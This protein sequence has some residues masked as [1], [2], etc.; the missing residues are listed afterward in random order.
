MS[1]VEAQAIT[2]SLQ[3]SQ[4]THLNRRGFLRQALYATKLLGLGTLAAACSPLERLTAPAQKTPRELKILMTTATIPGVNEWIEIW[5]KRWGLDNKIVVD[6]V[7]MGPSQM[8]D[9]IKVDGVRKE[10]DIVTPTRAGY[11]Y[12]FGEQFADLDQLADELGNK[13]GGWIDQA[14]NIAQVNGRW[15][16]IPLYYSPWAVLFKKDLFGKVGAS[17]DTTWESLISAGKLLKDTGLPQVGIPTSANSNDANISWNSFLLAYGASFISQDGKTV[18]I[19]SEQTRQ[20]LTAGI[21]LI[22]CL[23]FNASLWNDDANNLLFVKGDLAWIHNTIGLFRALQ[24]NT[25]EEAKKI[26]VALPPQGP[27]GRF[28][29]ASAIQFAVEKAAKQPEAARAFIRDFTSGFGPIFEVSQ[30]NILPFLKG[31]YN[32]P[33]DFIRSDPAIS[34]L[35]GIEQYLFFPGYPG[36]TNIAAAEVEGYSVIPKMFQTAYETQDIEKAIAAAEKEL[37]AIYA[38]VR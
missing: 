10:F 14:P 25:P 32:Q 3:T 23:P 34:S 24:K 19:N 17:P 26:G 1:L 18:T 2:E 29:S 5:S 11:A 28:T 22:D 37:R 16:V 7:W 30:G 6:F 38:K 27:A 15:K 4:P 20:A 13:F 21:E 8:Q 12:R 36:P 35:L 31:M 9:G 33:L